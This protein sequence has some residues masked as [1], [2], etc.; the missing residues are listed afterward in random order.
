VDCEFCNVEPVKHYRVST[1]LG[2]VAALCDECARKH[3]R[4]G[5]SINANG[6]PWQT[7]RL[8]NPVFFKG[9]SYVG[10]QP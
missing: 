9:A 7:A 3:G 2:K 5:Q 10:R 6:R 4:L 8:V 1:R